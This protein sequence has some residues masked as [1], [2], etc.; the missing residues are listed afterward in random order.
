MKTANFWY[1]KFIRS[2]QREGST[3]AIFNGLEEQIAIG[4]NKALY[5]E[6][7]TRHN[8]CFLTE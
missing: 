1:V 4:N 2:D 8:R 6:I 7:C 5:D 3:Y